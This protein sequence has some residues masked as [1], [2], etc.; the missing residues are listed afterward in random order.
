MNY[1]TYSAKCSG[2]KPRR[3]I[4][5]GNGYW[6]INVEERTLDFLHNRNILGDIDKA[7]ERVIF[8]GI[9]EDLIR[10]F[11]IIGYTKRR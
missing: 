5:Q 10:E 7:R 8:E 9:V 11:E 4:Q 6:S 3:G 1:G 2:S